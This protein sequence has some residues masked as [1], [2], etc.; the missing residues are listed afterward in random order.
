MTR[1]RKL[2]G[3]VLAVVLIGFVL[4]AFGMGF[5]A[6]K[7]YGGIR[8]RD[9]RACHQLGAEYHW[10]QDRNRCVLYVQP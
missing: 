6:A 9:A 3:I 8:E 2:V 5:Q 10:W 1:T 7:H 4:V